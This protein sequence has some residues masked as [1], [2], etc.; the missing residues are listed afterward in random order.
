M[1]MCAPLVEPC[2]ASYI[3]VLTRSSCDRFWS[4]SGQRLTDGQIGRG[5]TLDH[6]R[7]ATGGAADAGVVDDAGGSNLAGALAVEEVAGINAVQQE[8]VTGVA[9]AIGPD[10]LIAKPAVGAGPAGQFGVH[11]GRKNGEAR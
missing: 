5:G 3:E 4:G 7:A 1:S 8:A 9:L 10:G 11:A 2:W 6:R